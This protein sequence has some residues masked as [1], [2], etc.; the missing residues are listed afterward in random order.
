MSRQPRLSEALIGGNTGTDWTRAGNSRN[1]TRNSALWDGTSLLTQEQLEA[2]LLGRER[3]RQ[4]A[5]TAD[6]MDSFGDLLCE[7]LVHVHTTGMVHGRSE[8]LKHAGAF[9]RFV[10]VERGPLL[11]RPLG[12]DAAVMTG[13]MTNTVRRRDQDEEVTVQAYVTQVWVKRDGAW[14]IT[15]FHAVRTPEAPVGKP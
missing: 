8:V 11:I 6:D 4:R 7:D 10:R 2:E 3:E 1:G 5:L 14:R 12:P 15:S 9:L 13:P